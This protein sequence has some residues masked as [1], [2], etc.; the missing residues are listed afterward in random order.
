MQKHNR[1]YLTKEEYNARLK[2]F[3]NNLGLIKSNDP[4]VSGFKLGVNKFA[5]LSPQEWEK[6]Q[7]LRAIQKPVQLSKFLDEDD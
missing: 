7:G 3:S 5:D 4:N 6:M 2:I 1:N